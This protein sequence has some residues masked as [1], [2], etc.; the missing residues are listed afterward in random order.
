[1]ETKKNLFFSMI[2]PSYNRAHLL[3]NL[4]K[5]LKGQ[6]FKNFEWIVGDDGSTDNT[7]ELIKSFQKDADFTI[8]YF[9]F[10]HRGKA[11][12]FGEIY[13][14]ANGEYIFSVDSD[15]SLYDSKT[16]ETMYQK[17][18]GLP[19]DEK[20]GGVC[21]CHVNQYGTV[22]PEMDT[23]YFDITKENFFELWAE[24]SPLLNNKWI[25]RRMENGY[26]TYDHSDIK[27]F[28][29]F[30]PEIVDFMR[31]VMESKDYRYRLFNEKILAYTLNAEDCVTNLIPEY[32]L[33]WYETIGIINLFYEYNMVKKYNK[34][35]KEKVKA[36][37]RVIYKEKGVI[38][39][40]LALNCTKSRLCFI[41][42]YIICKITNIT[43]FIFS[44]TNEYSNNKKH[45]VVIVLGV[46]IK[47]KRAKNYIVSK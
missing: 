22:F 24:H 21:G 39:T 6:T 27:E 3:T 28:L 5:S 32:P 23:E 41:Y 43:S 44:I 26:R 37:A 35:I 38:K 19:A 10:E 11:A 46:K 33:R 7:E 2:T 15:D 17:I 4:Y 8:R 40:L 34:R 18:N 29:P 25:H 20:F 1:M 30:Y 42:Q 31:N 47:F 36:L 16:L 13:N 14:S 9:K 45:K 12:T